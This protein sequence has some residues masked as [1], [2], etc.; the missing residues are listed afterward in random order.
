MGENSEIISKNYLSLYGNGY[1]TW[2]VSNFGGYSE[3]NALV[4]S[5][6]Q[7][8]SHGWSGYGDPQYVPHVM[9]YYQ[10]R[11]GG[12]V[13]GGLLVQVAKSQLGNQGGQPYWSWYG[14]ESR[15]PWCACFVSWCA[16]QCGYLEAGLVPKFSACEE[17][18]RWFTERGQYH[19][20]DHVP[21][22]GDLVFF[23]WG[24]DGSY[25]HVG[26]VEYVEAGMVHTI[27][28]N[29][30]DSCAERSYPLGDSRICGFGSVGQL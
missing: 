18:I 30:S 17:G 29:T 16:D 15:Q 12:M 9:R 25:D 26:I 4:F 28:G 14:F 22:P 6:Q 11:G 7:A 1:I 24:S 23:D 19:P 20:R 3:A 5:Q 8:A 13:E 27:E 2:A 21:E 10:Y